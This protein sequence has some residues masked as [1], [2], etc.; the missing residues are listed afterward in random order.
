VRAALAV[1]ILGI[2]YLGLAPNDFA[3]L[4][5]LAGKALK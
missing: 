1:S 4:S 3:G 2:F 5:D